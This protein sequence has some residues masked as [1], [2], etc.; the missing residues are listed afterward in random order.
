MILEDLDSLSTETQ[1]TRAALLAQ[2][3]GL[4]ASD[5]LL[6]IG[7]T[8]N[9]YD[10]DTALLHR[11]SR[12]DRVWHFPL[13]DCNLRRRYLG[14]AFEDRDAAWLNGLAERTEGWTFAFLN[15]LR[16]TAAILSVNSGSA[17]ITN[18]CILESCKLLSTQVQAI[19]NNYAKAPP[20]GVFGFHNGDSDEC[21][22]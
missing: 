7:T 18:D 20:T 14:W 10:I 1:T 8:N 16:T 3:V 5:G 13:P 19:K 6:V 2:L 12:F 17:M 22:V 15:E 21:A 9:P 4:S 11:P